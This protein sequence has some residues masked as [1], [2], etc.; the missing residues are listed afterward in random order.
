M[1]LPV[2]A[3]IDDDLFFHLNLK[4]VI[5]NVIPDGEILTFY[6]GR[7]GY[8]FVVENASNPESLPDFILL[9]IEMPVMNGLQFLD[10][11][12]QVRKSFSKDIA[13]YLISTLS[14]LSHDLIEQYPFVKGSMAKPFS[15]RNLEE[16]LGA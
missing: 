16:L 14:E 15:K 10:R 3:I 5:K 8:D 7:E 1:K 6:N 11:F 9:D 4:A 12:E 13:I 2:V